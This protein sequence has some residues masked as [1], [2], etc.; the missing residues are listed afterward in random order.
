M[1][2]AGRAEQYARNVVS[3]GVAAC[4]YVALACQRHLGDLKAQEQQDFP[5]EFNTSAANRI[6]RFIELL[7]HVKGQWAERGE[8]LRLEPWQCFMVAVPFGWRWKATGLRRYRIAYIEVPRKNAKSTIS[9]AVGLYMFARDGEHGAE[10]YSGAGTEKQANEVFGP[11]RLMAKSTPELLEAFGI[12]VGAKNLSTLSNNSKFEP[13]IGKPGDGAS[14]SCSITDE[15]HEHATSEQLDTMLTGMGARE[16]PLAWVITTAGNS[17]EGPC[18]DLR[19]DV[20]KMLEGSVDNPELFGL[21]YTIDEGDAWDSVEALRKANPNA[22]V[23]T[24]EQYLL[25]Q[26]RDAIHNP[27]K[28]STY[29]TKHLNVWVTASSPYFNL[30][31]WKRL[32]D[33][34][35]CVEQFAGEPCWV[36]LDL[37]SKLDLTA[38]VRLF[39]R[40]QPGS[41]SRCRGTGRLADEPC[42]R[43]DGAGEAAEEHYYPFLKSYLPEERLG[44]AE[45][46]HYR[47]WAAGGWLSATA[48]NM[49]DYDEVEEDIVAD[50][51]RCP[52]AEL[53]FDPYNAAQLITHLVNHGIEC[54]E[55]PQTVPHLSEPMKWVQA[56]IEDGRFHHDGN[57]VLTWGISNVTAKEDRNQNVFPRKEKPE[58]KIDPCVAL[59]IAVGRAMSCTAK[60]EPSIFAIGS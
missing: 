46:A 7:P 58:N 8:Q 12:G 9:A 56:L 3:G 33:P 25:S 49:T 60:P 59:I 13:I 14:P 23:S 41:C 35:L 51:E 24:R 29:K 28:Q 50:A 1:S 17:I 42:P 32:A 15:Y 43:C 27:R 53:G 16:Q 19:S 39:V 10:V 44:P 11:A 2:H 18:Y 34:G 54:V 47:G 38:Y 48:G 22:G 21:I 37:A 36:G 20:V 52:V 6:C 26:L 31:K 45:S 30:E 5:F 4:R 40:E 55:V 57:P